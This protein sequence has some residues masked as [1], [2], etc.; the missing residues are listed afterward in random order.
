RRRPRRRRS[1]RRSAT[2]VADREVL[3]LRVCCGSTSELGASKHIRHGGHSG[4]LLRESTQNTDRAQPCGL[5]CLVARTLP[6][7]CRHDR[8]STT[9]FQNQALAFLASLAPW[10]SRC[11]EAVV[12]DAL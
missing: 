11:S 5:P 12:E 4:S 7:T 3:I 6:Q 1:R 2:T 8:A 9:P 10:R